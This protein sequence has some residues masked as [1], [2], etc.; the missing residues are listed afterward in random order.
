MLIDYS[1]R[2]FELLERPLTEHEKHEVFDVFYMVGEKMRLNDLPKKYEEYLILREQQLSYQLCGSNF[3]H[4]LYKQYRKH[5][6]PIRYWVLKQAQVLVVPKPV[7]KLLALGHIPWLRPVMYLYK[8][9]RL[10]KLQNL[11]KNAI[12]PKAYV[13][14]VQELDMV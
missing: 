10:L 9:F 14:Q 11:L 13:K 5:L 2:S 6:G 1:I 3:T 4:D 7:N 12:L 8:L